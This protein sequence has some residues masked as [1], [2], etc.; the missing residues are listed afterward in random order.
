MSKKNRDQKRV[1]TPVSYAD[2][3]HAALLRLAAQGMGL[4]GDAEGMRAAAFAAKSR[5]IEFGAV[6]DYLSAP[7]T[8]DMQG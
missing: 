7:K 2:L 6:L 4:R 1:R 5:A 8:E 3:E